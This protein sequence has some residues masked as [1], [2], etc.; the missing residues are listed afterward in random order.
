MATDDRHPSAQGGPALSGAD[1]RRTL[2]RPHFGSV[3]LKA[4]GAPPITG[5]LADIS[6]HGFRARH[7][8]PGWPPGHVVEFA[9]DGRSGRA[10]VIWTRP[11]GD[12]AESGF[13]VQST[14]LYP[15]LR[16]DPYNE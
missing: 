1:R 2:R 11:D 8:E 12:A 5:E 7:P 6:D 16:R 10:R 13:L 14:W 9:H 4:D 3:R 15:I